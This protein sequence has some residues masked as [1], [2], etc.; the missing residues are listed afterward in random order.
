MTAITAC[1][2]CPV[3][4]FFPFENGVLKYS[5]NTGN[6]SLNNLRK[7]QKFTV[8]FTVSI[9]HFGD[10]E[11]EKWVYVIPDNSGHILF[12][13]TDRSQIIKLKEIS[14]RENNLRLGFLILSYLVLILFSVKF[15]YISWNYWHWNPDLKS[16]FRNT[17]Q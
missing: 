3:T 15:E 12:G 13:I 9:A 17:C 16:F 5:K 11:A 2:I 6:L 1:F 14:F 10:I 4:S 7:F 8:Q